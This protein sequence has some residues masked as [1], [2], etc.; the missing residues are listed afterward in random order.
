MPAGQQLPTQGPRGVVADRAVRRRP[1]SLKSARRTCLCA[2]R[3]ER[4]RGHLWPAGRIAPQGGVARV[5]TKLH[6]DMLPQ[7]DGTTCGPTCL[8]A[9]Y[10]YYGETLE[11]SEVIDEVTSLAGGGTL[12]VCLGCHALRRGYDARIYTYNLQIYDPTWFEPGVAD[13]S[14][15]LRS[16]LKYKHEP[17]LQVATEAY[18]EFLDR[19]GQIR[20]QDLTPTLVRKYLNRGQPLLTGLSATYL[21]RT[22]RE[23]GSQLDADDLRGEPQGHFVVLC[24]YDKDQRRVLLA[25]PMQPNPLA[26][27]LRYLVHIDRLLCAILL[28]IVTYDANLLVITPRQ[29]HRLDHADSDRRE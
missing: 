9:L 22:A 6:V 1:V 18:L 2:G 3:S 25:D 28:G 16:Q 27:G 11:L 13:L 7:P 26:E 15:R 8:H 20:F 29:N 23:F 4:A 10:R 19:G 24:G 5:E 17:R 12:A 14:E 21:Y